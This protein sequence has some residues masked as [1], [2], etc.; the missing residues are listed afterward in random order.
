MD[1]SKIMTIAGK[2]GLFRIK[3][4]TRNGLVVESLLDGR[5]LPVFPTDRSSTL[6][7]ISIFTYE[8]EVPLKEVF[9]KIYKSAEGKP[10]PDPKSHPDELRAKFEEILPEYDKERVYVADIKKVFNWYNILLEHDLISETE[11]EEGKQEEGKQEEGKQEEGKQE[12]KKQES[13]S[14]KDDKKDKKDKE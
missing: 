9:Q 4:Q 12:D 7:D 5:K 13:G 11:E 3:A 6:E 14:K 8:K 10:G 1:L 2:P